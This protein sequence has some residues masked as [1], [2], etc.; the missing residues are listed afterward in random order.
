MKIKVRLSDTGYPKIS[1]EREKTG[2]GTLTIRSVSRKGK[3]R[4]SKD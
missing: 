1:V 4:N 3:K 2:V